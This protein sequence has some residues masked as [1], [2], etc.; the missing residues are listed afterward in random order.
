[1]NVVRGVT[2]VRARKPNVTGDVR[3]VP[4]INVTPTNVTTISTLKL[5]LIT[6][7]IIQPLIV[8]FEK[9]S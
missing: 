2:V 7:T 9:I 4:I 8:K 6:F 3:I 1:M 5:L